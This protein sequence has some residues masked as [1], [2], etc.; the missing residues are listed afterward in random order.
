MTVSSATLLPL[1]LQRIREF[2][3]VEDTNIRGE[4]WKALAEPVSTLE[5]LRSRE[6]YFNSALGA[7]T[8]EESEVYQE[9]VKS[10]T[11]RADVTHSVTQP[12][13]PKLAEY[14]SAATLPSMH[15]I[16]QKKGNTTIR[17]PDNKR[18]LRSTKK[19]GRL[20]IQMVSRKNYE[21]RIPS[22]HPF[23]ARG[24]PFP[25]ARKLLH[26]G[27]WGFGKS[28]SKQG[29]SDVVFKSASATGSARSDVK[30]LLVEVKC[31]W[32]LPLAEM[33]EI[34]KFHN[35]LPNLS[36]LEAVN[37]RTTSPRKVKKPAYTSGEHLYHILNSSFVTSLQAQRVL[38]QVYDY[39]R[40]QKHQFFIITTYEYWM[41]GV[42]SQD[43]TLAAVTEPLPYDH[44]GPTIL[45]CI[46][47]WLQSSLFL[48]GSFEI[49]EQYVEE[50]YTKMAG[51]Q[52]QGSSA[53][54][55]TLPTLEDQE[56]DELVHRL[57]DKVGHTS[58]LTHILLYPR[59]LPWSYAPD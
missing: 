35:G 32:T 27:D 59:S 26:H 5:G 50:N 14:A 16:P 58:D 15:W 18:H 25:I 11:S 37:E 19:Q 22:T 10:Y 4:T 7:F 34:V 41:F 17:G 20:L 49:P 42:F 55:R 33:G 24:A 38:A 9:L 31:P 48:P 40:E 57:V 45:Q 23:K 28:T 21:F 46:T 1:Y 29:L 54:Y 44:K 30:R 12:G 53:Q 39:C 6:S 43:Y 52:Y 8:E 36:E 2:A 3:N 47:Y 13:S 56:V 51:Q